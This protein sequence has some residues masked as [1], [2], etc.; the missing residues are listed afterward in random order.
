MSKVWRQISKA[1]IGVASN[2]ETI[3]KVEEIRE[4]LQR[5]NTYQGELE[6]AMND[7]LEEVSPIECHPSYNLLGY[8]C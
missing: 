2:V 5:Y 6:L 7:L 4:G 3:E 8:W 1:I